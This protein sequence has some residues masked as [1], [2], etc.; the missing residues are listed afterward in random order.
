MR[1]LGPDPIGL[2]LLVVLVVC[3]LVGYGLAR[4]LAKPVVARRRATQA[5]AEGSRGVRGA[6]LVGRRRDEIGALA[7]DFDRMADRVAGLIDDQRQL[8]RDVSHE[9]RSPLARLA[10]ALELA[11]QGAGE[12]A[13]PQLD[14]IEREAERLNVLIGEMLQ[15]AQVDAAAT[16]HAHEPVQLDAL[17]RQVVADAEFEGQHQGRGVDLVEAVPLLVMGLEEVLRRAIEN[18]VRNAVRFTAEGTRVEVRLTRRPTP[19]GAEACVVVRDHGPGVPEADLERIFQPFVRVGPA[20]D[21]QSG[22]TGIGLAVTERAVR[23]HGGAVAAR[24]AEGGGLAVTV[25]LP[26]SGRP[27][28]MNDSRSA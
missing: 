5:L 23:L 17:L 9:L 4:Y 12:A 3:G 25:S 27:G 16:G 11:R 20:R 21:R 22:G 18:V 6:P 7:R 24:N 19:A 1:F 14:R 8:L 13:V 28:R 2:R 26:L 10:V 15:A